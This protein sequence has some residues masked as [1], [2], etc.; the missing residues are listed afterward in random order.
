MTGIKSPSEFVHIVGAGLAG[1]EAAWQV[2]RSGIRVVLHEM[3]PDRM[4]QAHRTDGLAE[5]VCSNSFRSDDAANNAVGLLH[6]EMRRLGSLIMRAADANQVPAGGALAVDR[7][8]FSAAVTKALHDHPLIEIRRGEIDGLPPADWRNVIVATGPLTSAP[9]ADAIC[10]LTDENA[11]AFFDAIA[12]IV[13]KDSIDMSAAW[14]QSRYDKMGPG[15]TG[16]DYIN[17]PLTKEQYDGFV[18]ALVSGEK[19]DFKEWETNTPYFDGCLPIEVMAE[20]G[21]ETLRH[22]PMKP[23]GLTNAHNPTAK[24][25]AVAQ[26]R[27]DNALG[28]LFNIVG[29]QTKLKYG[30]Q[31]RIFRMIPG[32]EG[33]EFARLGGMHRNTYLNSPRLLDARLRLKVAPRLRFAGQI[34]GCEGYVESA[35]VGLIAGRL[36]AAERLG[37]ELAPPPTTTA[38]GALLNHITGGHIESIDPGPRSFQPMNVN[39][40][41]FPPIAEPRFDAA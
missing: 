23:F 12:P 30:E 3:R 16:A 1:S 38:I 32:L 34:T 11:L 15:G 36:A 37:A 4:T 21:R 40:G 35:A 26:L 19:T 7:D 17:C 24:P 2:A 13:H 22:G 33:A 25:Y 31:S 28:T 27:Q 20:R 41:L 10:E 29:F 8:G 14:F 5:L 9:L 6:A 39:F 18:D